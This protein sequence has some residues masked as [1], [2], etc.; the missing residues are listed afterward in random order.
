MMELTKE[1]VYA[2]ESKGLL[3][4][5]SWAPL[6]IR[7]IRQKVTKKN[8]PDDFMKPCRKQR[9]MEMRSAGVK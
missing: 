9:K 4:V 2:V 3:I 6:P 1:I 5:A 7:R 8:Q